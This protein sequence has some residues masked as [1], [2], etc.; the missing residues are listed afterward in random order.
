[1]AEQIV[2][3]IWLFQKRRVPPIDIVAGSQIPIALEMKDY[4]IPSGATVKVYARPWG[5]ETTYVQ[6]AAVSGNMVVFTPQDGF[7][8]EGWNA[9]QL[10]IDGSKIPLA[11]DVNG[12]VRL[13]DGGGGAT[14]EAV[15]PLVARAEEAA[16]AAAGQAAEAKA[17]ADAAETSAQGIRD[18][19]EKIDRNAEDVSQLKEDLANVNSNVKFTPIWGANIYVGDELDLAKERIDRARALSMSEVMICVNFQDDE[20]RD[21]YHAY[22]YTETYA[23]I[24]KILEYAYSVGIK[25]AAIKI[26]RSPEMDYSSMDFAKYTKGLT[27]LHGYISKSPHRPEYMF[28]LNENSLTDSSAND[29][30]IVGVINSVHNFGYKCGISMF[31]SY[32]YVSKTSIAVLN[33]L[34]VI[35]I[36][37]Y[38]VIS[39]KDDDTTVSDS[40]SA[41]TNA[42]VNSHITNI[43]HYA[44]K[45]VWIT[46]TGMFDNSKAFYF[47][48]DS[49]TWGLEKGD[50]EAESIYFEGCFYHLKN[51]DADKVFG[52]D[53]DSMYSDKMIALCKKYML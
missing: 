32:Q 40:I 21:F 25:V 51:S 37:Y 14:P 4:T 28:I 18:S 20:N 13:S 35:G 34:D 19:A 8:Q 38:E 29:G 11:L 2:R 50:G 7:F 10:E 44:K 22:N 12:G 1:M 5:R 9:V 16:K 23:N 26:H 41:W 3:E 24:Y 52:W 15:R 48:A 47:P 30:T 53:I 17:S 33:N 49:W 43:K 36:N 6:N 39:P 46:E 27:A 42:N 31:G 45:P